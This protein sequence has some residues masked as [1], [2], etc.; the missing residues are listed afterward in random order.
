[1][2]LH[3]GNIHRIQRNHGLKRADVLDFSSNIN[4]L[5]VAESVRKALID[6]IEGV[7][8]Y[9]DPDYAELRSALGSYN[10]MDA[11]DIIVGNGSIELLFLAARILVPHKALIVGPTFMEYERAVAQARGHVSYFRLM[12][13]D[14]FALHADPLYEELRNGYD[15]LVLCNPNNPTGCFV[16]PDLMHDIIRRAMNLD[17]FIILDEAF[18]EFVEG[19]LSVSMAPLASSCE[20]LLI[21]RSLTKFFALPGLRLGY[22]I[23]GS[24]HFMEK[25][26]AAKEPWTVNSLAECAGRAIVSDSEYS[27][28]TREWLRQERE[29]IFGELSTCSSLKCYPTQANF[30]L[31]QMKGEISAAEVREALIGQGIVIRD[32]SNFTFLDQRFIRIAIKDRQSNAR[33]TREL[34]RA[35][36]G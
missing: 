3:G 36:E 31:L 22:G 34:K 25:L 15:L 13:E 8:H 10:R 20:N 27:R 2:E 1:M 24:S 11:A 17:I 12:E 19:G 30:V 9:P 35:L 28:R 23:T 14:N 6:N 16:E 32:A 7:I 18:I 5:G 21:L 33:L 29:F 4:P 26:L